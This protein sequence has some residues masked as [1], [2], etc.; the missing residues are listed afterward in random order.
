MF[1][2]EMVEAVKDHLIGSAH[3]SLRTL[4]NDPLLAATANLR[5]N[6]VIAA[7]A[8]TLEMFVAVG[9]VEPEVAHRLVQSTSLI[10]RVLHDDES[11]I[12]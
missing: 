8:A 4:D 6:V 7:L 5:G 1:E 10:S 11:V 9:K 12:D 2:D 3:D